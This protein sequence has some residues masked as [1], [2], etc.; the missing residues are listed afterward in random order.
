MLDLANGHAVSLSFC[1]PN[2]NARRFAPSGFCVDDA[3]LYFSF[4]K[5]AV[6]LISPRTAR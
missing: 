3:V 1:A 5:V 4:E 2:V 6:S